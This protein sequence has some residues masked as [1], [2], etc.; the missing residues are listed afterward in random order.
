MEGIGWYCHELVSRM[1]KNHPEH[2]FYFFFDRP[3]DKDFIYADNVHPVVLIPP[4]RHVFLIAYWF[5]VSLRRALKKLD[6]DVFFSP[7]SISLNRPVCKTIVTLHDVNFITNPDNFGFLLRRFYARRTPILTEKS[8]KI[9]TVSEHSSKEIQRLLQVHENKIRV[10]YNACRSGFEPVSD[11]IK[12]KIKSEY[13]DGKDYFVFVGGLYH[14]KN[15]LRLVQA[16]ELFKDKSGSDIK[17]VIIGRKVG[18]ADDLIERIENSRFKTD[19]VL[20]GRISEDGLV[21]KILASALALTYVSVLE[22]FGMPMVEA[23]KSGLP[24]LASNTSSMPEIG[25]NAAIYADPYNVEDIALKM[26]ELYSSESLR[27]ELIKNAAIQG[28]KFDW[29]KSA[30]EL[31]KVIEELTSG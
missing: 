2:D 31:W 22:G 20:T 30:A 23:M 13:T 6:A 17:L 5:D 11:A 27:K 26:N 12:A 10:I 3:F 16:F 28:Q 15:L 8:D 25:G 9:L 14:R 29:D 7:D 19:I 21:K 1:V 4:A 18:E 24:I